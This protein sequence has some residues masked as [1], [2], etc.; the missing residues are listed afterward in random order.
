VLN[1]TT[2]PWDDY[3]TN[4]KTGLDALRSNLATAPAPDAQR[5]AD[6]LSEALS[7]GLTLCISGAPTDQLAAAVNAIGDAQQALGDYIFA[8]T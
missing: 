3:T 6:N 4:L 1:G 7:Q 2:P 8:A 5:L